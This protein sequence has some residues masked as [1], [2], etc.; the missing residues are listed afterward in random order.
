MGAFGK[1]IRHLAG[2]LVGAAVAWLGLELGSDQTADLTAGLTVVLM[3]VM[4]VA[5]SF[6]EKFLKRFG[7]LDP[8]GAADRELHKNGT[9]PYTGNRSGFIL[10]LLLVPFTMFATACGPEPET[11]DEIQVDTVQGGSSVED[12]DREEPIRRHD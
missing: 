2:W 10:A 9:V 12:I 6:V 4:G 7:K 1:Y 3:L 11:T 5:Y 8:E